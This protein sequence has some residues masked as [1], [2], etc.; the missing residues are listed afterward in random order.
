MR[1]LNE[2]WNRTKKRMEQVTHLISPNE[3]GKVNPSLKICDAPDIND[4]FYL[5][6][7][8]FPKQNAK[9]H[10]IDSEDSLE[11]ALKK[12]TEKIYIKIGRNSCRISLIS[13]PCLRSMSNTFFS[14]S[15]KKQ[16]NKF[17]YYQ[18]GALLFW[19][20]IKKIFF[21]EHLYVELMLW[22]WMFYCEFI[23]CGW[24]AFLNFLISNWFLKFKF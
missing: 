11:Y 8:F 18:E 21:F 12:A 2:K 13:F 1:N 24:S 3:R 6:L 15:I 4:S 14:V 17:K 9:W 19:W 5:C 10:T 23:E 20:S 22:L 7:F 16:Q